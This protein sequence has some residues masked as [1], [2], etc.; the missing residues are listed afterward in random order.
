LFWAVCHLHHAHIHTC[1]M[2]EKCRVISNKSQI[3]Y[4]WVNVR[5]WKPATLQ[6]GSSTVLL[7]Q[8]VSLYM[9]CKVK[10]DTNNPKDL[11]PGPDL[12][13]L[14]EHDI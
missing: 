6:F 12:S 1:N 4:A 8:N 14:F 5:M 9:V 2:K 13:Y 10:K 7:I 3:V 11:D